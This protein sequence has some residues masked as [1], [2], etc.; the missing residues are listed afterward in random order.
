ME[1][2]VDDKILTS[3]WDFPKTLFSVF[4]Q[5]VLSA[6]TLISLVMLKFRKIRWV[7]G[8]KRKRKLCFSGCCCWVTKS[9]PT[10]LQPHGLDCSPPG[11]SVHG[12]SQAR[13]LEWLAISFS[14]GSS[15]LRDL[16]SL[17]CLAGGFFTTEPPLSIYPSVDTDC[18][19]ILATV[20]TGAHITPHGT[21]VISFGNISRRRIPGSHGG[22][23]F[24][25]WKTS[26]LFSIVAA[27]FCIL[28]NSAQGFHFLHILTL[29]NF[30]Y[31]FCW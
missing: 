28:T 5:V 26:I 18:F 4:M 16:T 2:M 12:I 21:D 15:W 29:V 1:N 9:C 14:R 20:N 30:Y 23:I 24:N 22:S 7:L 25:I 6:L 11:S 10:V 8:H 31:F 13:T 17:S 19:H 3:V 27:P